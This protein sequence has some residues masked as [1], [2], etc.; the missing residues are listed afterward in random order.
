MPVRP[1]LLYRVTNFA[2]SLQKNGHSVRKN[3]NGQRE[4][5]Y[6]PPQ[7]SG[8][9]PVKP[10]PIFC[11]NR[12]ESIPLLHAARPPDCISIYGLP[13]MCR[14]AERVPAHMIYAPVSL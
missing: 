1:A 10:N 7:K 13:M 9:P 2:H 6:I 5:R 12:D 3:E 11:S 8:R 14:W 4:V